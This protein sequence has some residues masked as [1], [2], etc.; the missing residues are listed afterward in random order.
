MCDMSNHFP[1]LYYSDCEFVFIFRLYRL[2]HDF[3]SMKL[4]YLV[5]SIHAM[6]TMRVLCNVYIQIHI[7]DLYVAAAKK[8]L[9]V[10]YA[11]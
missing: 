6:Q 5:A 10:I 2:V 3:H 11:K 8:H 9:I 7:C 1:K 4:V